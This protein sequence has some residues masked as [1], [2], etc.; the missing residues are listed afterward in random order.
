MCP[1]SRNN[2]SVFVII[3]LI[4]IIIHILLRKIYIRGI[5]AYRSKNEQQVCVQHLSDTFMYFSSNCL[6]LWCLDDTGHLTLIPHT[7]VHLQSGRPV[8]LEKRDRLDCPQ[9]VQTSTNAKISTKIDLLQIQISR[10]IRIRM[11]AR[12]LP[13]CCGF[14]TLSASVILPSVVKIC[15]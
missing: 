6:L 15:R 11:S 4:L 13:I 1:S 14:S 9:R 5:F 3:F 12:S 8:W 10:L 2:P 7:T